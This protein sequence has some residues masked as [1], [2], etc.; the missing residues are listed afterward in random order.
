LDFGHWFS[1]PLSPWIFSLR[2]I[3]CVSSEIFVEANV[4]NHQK[5]R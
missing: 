5:Q 2:A 4:P 1:S 3:S